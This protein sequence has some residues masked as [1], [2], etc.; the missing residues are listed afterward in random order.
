MGMS[1]LAVGSPLGIA[2]VAFGIGD[3]MVNLAQ[4][5]SLGASVST[6]VHSEAHAAVDVGHQA[7]H[8][9]DDVF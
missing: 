1:S 6:A 4:G 2:P 7:E 9:W 3:T 8:L 5:K